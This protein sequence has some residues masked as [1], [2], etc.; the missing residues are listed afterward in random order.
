MRGWQKVLIGAMMSLVIIA[1]GVTLW[2]H[3]R[4]GESG[5]K[6]PSTQAPENE[7]VVITPS[8]DRIPKGK[9]EDDLS[10]EEFNRLLDELLGTKGEKNESNEGSLSS[11]AGLT[12]NRVENQ[13]ENE[14][15]GVEET[16]QDEE[17]S[18]PEEIKRRI[19][20][21]VSDISSYAQQIKPLMDRA[22][23]MLLPN[24]RIS[25]GDKL[26]S[27]GKEALQYALELKKLQ[28]DGVKIIKTRYLDEISGLHIVGY[29]IKVL[30]ELGESIPEVSRYLPIEVVYSGPENGTYSD[31]AERIKERVRSGKITR[32][33]MM[34][35]A[36]RMAA[37]EVH[38]ERT[39]I[40]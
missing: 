11:S 30:P 15:P 21:L 12:M 14:K 8:E 23:M 16:K 27:I 29:E 22:Q 39:E 34:D 10:F 25:D 24:E 32:E 19:V 36:S 3:N 7:K 5:V 9:G 35:F 33:K 40:K 18:M 17:G 20:Q 28:P 6:T 4:G 31:M 37:G 1:G 13:V 2:R 38:I 26:L